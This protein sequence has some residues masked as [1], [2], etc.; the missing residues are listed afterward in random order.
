[1]KWR[2]M[3]RAN[4]EPGIREHI[5]GLDAVIPFVTLLG[6]LGS[7]WLNMS[8]KVS[9][10]ETLQEASQERLPYIVR[11]AIRTYIDS[12]NYITRPEFDRHNHRGQIDPQGDPQ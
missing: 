2:T 11:E 4:S 10:L 5:W 8:L 1:M 9:R 3:T 7:M 6:I 12:V